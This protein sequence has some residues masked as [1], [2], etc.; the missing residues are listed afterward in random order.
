MRRTG[1]RNQRGPK[2]KRQTTYVGGRVK[3][4]RTRVNLNTKPP[5]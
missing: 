5:L 4:E 1:I 3:E 2:A